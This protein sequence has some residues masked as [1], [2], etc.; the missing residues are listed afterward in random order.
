VLTSSI[1]TKYYFFFKFYSCL[2]FQLLTL[3]G[4]TST[5]SSLVIGRTTKGVYFHWLID[6]KFWAFKLI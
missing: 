2:L 1:A 4:D 6:L 3:Q 5:P